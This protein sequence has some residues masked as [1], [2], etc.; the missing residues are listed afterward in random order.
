V[1]EER[2]RQSNPNSNSRISGFKDSAR[3]PQKLKKNLTGKGCS[4]GME[5]E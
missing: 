5:R 4:W 1:Q 2:G 3:E